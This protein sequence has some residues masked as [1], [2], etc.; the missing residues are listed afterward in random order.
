MGSTERG[1]DAPVNRWGA[2]I[3]GLI[4][5]L[6]FALLFLN[7]QRQLVAIQKARRQST[8]APAATTTTTR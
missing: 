4:L 7:L 6:M 3:A 2:R 1:K 5:L 8:P